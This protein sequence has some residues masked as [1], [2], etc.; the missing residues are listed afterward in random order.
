MK[1]IFY[2]AVDDV[3]FDFVAANIPL[4]DISKKYDLY[5]L[6]SGSK[7]GSVRKL[8]PKATI[9]KSDNDF[10]LK[11]VSFFE[12][13]REHKVKGDVIIRLDVDAVVFDVEWLLRIVEQNFK[14]VNLGFI[15]NLVKRSKER[16]YIRGACQAVT[17]ELADKLQLQP[18]GDSNEYDYMFNSAAVEAGCTYVPYKLFEVTEAYTANV[19]VW[20]PP[21]I[22]VLEK[23]LEYFVRHVKK[24]KKFYRS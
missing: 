24:Y 6:S 12:H 1:P 15:G 7:T 13:I 9:L 4:Q 19:P 11:G 8:F 10:Q 18:T 5:L 3:I 21:K 23:R 22:K 2:V 17:R 16:I 20:H 14:G